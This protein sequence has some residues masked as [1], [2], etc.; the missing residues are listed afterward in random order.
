[1]QQDK[2]PNDIT[3]TSPGSFDG[4]LELGTIQFVYDLIS[5]FFFGDL[6]NGDVKDSL[7]FNSTLHSQKSIYYKG[8]RLRCMHAEAEDYIFA[9]C[10]IWMIMVGFFIIITTEILILIGLVFPLLIILLLRGSH[11]RSYSRVL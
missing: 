5:A 3:Y 6:N 4:S 8:S 1:V 11:K 10:V 9:I 7:H 2:G